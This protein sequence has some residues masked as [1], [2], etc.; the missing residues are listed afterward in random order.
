MRSGIQR[1]FPHATLVFMTYPIE[2]MLV[3]NAIEQA[4]VYSRPL[5]IEIIACFSKRT[6]LSLRPFLQERH[7]G[8]TLSFQIG[9]WP[10]DVVERQAGAG[11]AA[12]AL[13]L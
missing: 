2:E 1:G 5:D 12:M 13:D 9:A 10:R 8:A 7:F 3:P 11:I 6:R 4:V